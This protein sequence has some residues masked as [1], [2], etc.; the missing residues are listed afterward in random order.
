[1]IFKIKSGNFL[2]HQ[3]EWWELPNYIK[4]LVGGFGCGKTYISALRAIW[5]SYVNSG[6]P[7]LYVSPSYKFA[8][9]TIIPTLRGIL[10][11]AN[12]EFKHNKTDNDIRI[13]NWNGI[14]W[15]GSGDDPDS[16]RGQNLAAGLI[17]EPF[18]QDRMVF[19]IVMSRIRHPKAKHR[20]LG[21]VGTPEELNWGHEIAMNDGNKRDVGL[22][23]GSTMDN[24]HLPDQFKKSLTD[25]YSEEMVDAYIHGKFVNLSKGR[26][27]K[28]FDREKHCVHRK[29][30]ENLPVIAG[31]DFNV[32]YMTAILMRKAPTFLHI[33]DEIRLS[34][35]N[36][37]ELADA[38]QEKYPRIAVYP[39]ASGS[40]RRS[41]STQ[42]DHDILR[43]S[44]FQVFSHR[45][46]PPVR[47]RVNSVNR[48][49]MRGLLT[50][51]NC[52]NLTADLERNV[53]RSGDID[54]RDIAMTHAG[55]ALGYPVNYLF[56]IVQQ[57]FG[58]ISL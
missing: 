48:L 46:N 10:T 20:E 53:W 32:D 33:F 5:L 27:Y 13:S 17:D 7:V 3:K 39:D 47:Q 45:S 8:K 44:G 58:E 55:D 21:M 2:K 25:S 42:S 6:I 38:L 34:N 23:Y 54:K 12:I 43:Q 9:R 57:N 41:S 28:P 36:T 1:M 4:L 22:V 14:I 49:L 18:I 11:R 31:I 15:I 16:L 40:A 52:P 51:E 35:S 29:D 19:D 37:F 24:Q 26:V 30:L 50:V 56:P